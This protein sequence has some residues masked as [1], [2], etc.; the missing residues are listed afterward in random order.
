M[1]ETSV[2]HHDLPCHAAMT[3]SLVLIP[4]SIFEACSAFT[5]VMD[6]ILAGSP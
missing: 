1:H 4:L 3:C 6:C 5:H 2:A